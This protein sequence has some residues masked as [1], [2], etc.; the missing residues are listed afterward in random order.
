MGRMSTPRSVLQVL[1]S[2][3]SDAAGD[4]NDCID[5]SFRGTSIFLV[6]HTCPSGSHGFSET[7]FSRIL[8][9][10]LGAGISVNK[11]KVAMKAVSIELPAG[12]AKPISAGCRRISLR[13]TPLIQRRRERFWYRLFRSIQVRLSGLLDCS[14]YQQVSLGRE[15]AVA[16]TSQGPVL[17]RPGVALCESQIANRR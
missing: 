5:S 12:L 6:D 11:P 9:R 17:Y 10:A 2:Y 13:P 8:C 16:F 15:I 4:R 14:S 3:R 1:H 7:F